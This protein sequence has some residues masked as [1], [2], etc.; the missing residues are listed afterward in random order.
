MRTGSSM[1]IPISRVPSVNDSLSSPP[2]YNHIEHHLKQPYAHDMY[3]KLQQNS[4]SAFSTCST[5]SSFP[6]PEYEKLSHESSPSLFQSTSAPVF[7]TKQQSN[8]S[9]QT[10][11]EPLYSTLKEVDGEG[12]EDESNDIDDIATTISDDSPPPPIPPRLSKM[13]SI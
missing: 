5:F 13:T 7:S 6:I 9:V 2:Q 4:P 12:H 3:T 1:I 11:A 8:S 10:P